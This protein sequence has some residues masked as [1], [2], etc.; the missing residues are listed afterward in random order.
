LQQFASRRGGEVL[1]TVEPQFFVR[2]LDPGRADEVFGTQDWRGV[3]G[4]SAD[5]KRAF[6]A[7]QLVEAIHRA[8]FTYVI[9]FGLEADRGNELL[10]QFGTNHERGLEKFKDSLWRADPIGGARFRDPNDPE[11]MLLDLTPEPTLAPLRRL[12]LGYLAKQPQQTAKIDQLRTF[13]RNRTIYREPHTAPALDELRDRGEITTSPPQ[14][15]IASHTRRAVRVTATTTEQY[16]L[17]DA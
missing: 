10:L 1:V 16:G 3:D 8:G 2:N 15:R 7:T 14:A 17:F 6:I 9:S 12:L 4:L 11:Q 13:T 5:E